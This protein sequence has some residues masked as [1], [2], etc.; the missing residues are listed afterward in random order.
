MRSSRRTETGPVS[1]VHERH[2]VDALGFGINWAGQALSLHELEIEARELLDPAVYDF[3]AG[4]AEDEVTLRA[5]ESAF[6]RI[7]LV[8]RVMCGKQMPD[9]SITLLGQS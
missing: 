9:L 4:G 5:N 2:S 7:G 1:T 6:R 8:P 3:V